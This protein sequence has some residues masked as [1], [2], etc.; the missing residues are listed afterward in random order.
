MLMSVHELRSD[1]IV[2]QIG[3]HVLASIGNRPRG[4]PKQLAEHIPTGICSIVRSLSAKPRQKEVHVQTPSEGVISA[5]T[6]DV[7]SSP[8]N[9]GVCPPVL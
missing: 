8:P 3:M 4:G 7:V 2:C 9:F 6:I 5:E 1:P